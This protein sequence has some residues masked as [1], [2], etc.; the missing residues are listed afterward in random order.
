MIMAMMLLFCVF[1]S[2]LP[3]LPYSRNLF[4]EILSS[5]LFGLLRVAAFSYHDWL[6][7]APRGF[8]GLR[9]HSSIHVLDQKINCRTDNKSVA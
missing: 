4:L 8:H 5:F 2:F 1:S 6:E 3:S 7:A 9:S